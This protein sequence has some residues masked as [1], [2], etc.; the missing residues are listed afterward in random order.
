M[1]ELSIFI[2]ESG[3][4]GAYDYHSPFYI[5]TMVFHDQAADLTGPLKKLENDLTGIGFPNHCV[6]TGPIIRRENDYKYVNI[7]ERRRILNYMAAFVRHIDIKYH[8]VHVE[9]AHIEDN[10]EIVAQLSRKIASFLKENYNKLKTYDNIKIYY[11]NGQHEVS[12]IL[13]SVFSVLLPSVTIKRVVPSDYRLF[14]VADFLCSIELVKLKQQ[15]S[16]LSS[17]ELE[18]FGNLRDLKK[19]YIRPLERKEW[20]L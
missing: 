14:Q 12:K 1:K 5:I 19:N 10:L 3:D 2:D 7:V 18:F 17:S 9:K 6:H 4:F 16:S 11:D 13:V 20:V 15:N 8:C